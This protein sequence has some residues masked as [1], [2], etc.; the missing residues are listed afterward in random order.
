MSA[1]PKSWVLIVDDV[2]RNLQVVGT[3]LRNEGYQVMPALSGPQAL[4]RVQEQPPDLILLDLMMP[5][6]DGERFRAEQLK[7]PG[8]KSIPVVILSARTD[9]PRLAR[10]LDCPYL[11]KPFEVGALLDTVKRYSSDQQVLSA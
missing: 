4:E 7:R 8:L 2:A 10:R 9:T 6:M 3:L 5:T 1:L 11:T